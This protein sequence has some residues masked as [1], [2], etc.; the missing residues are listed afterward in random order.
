MKTT[1]IQRTTQK[2]TIRPTSLKQSNR[3]TSSAGAST[4]V[5]SII[6]EDTIVKTVAKLEN[7]AIISLTSKRQLFTRNGS[8]IDSSAIYKNVGQFNLRFIIFNL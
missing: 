6:L 5:P 4:V 3:S 8:N 2:S 7:L 1:R